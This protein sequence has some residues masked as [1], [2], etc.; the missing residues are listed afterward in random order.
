M[1]AFCLHCSALYVEMTL[2]GWQ[3]DS[4]KLKQHVRCWALYVSAMSVE[5]STEI[6]TL[7]IC[8]NDHQ[9]N[10][11]TDTRSYIIALNSKLRCLLKQRSLLGLPRNGQATFKNIYSVK[12][13]FIPSV[14]VHIF[15]RDRK[16]LTVNAQWTAS[17]RST[18]ALYPQASK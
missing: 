13:T 7:P 16:H 1:Y 12:S 15:E 10:S 18:F 8:G 17:P 11:S 14:T 4:R 9:Y 6:M 3:V 2:S 5:N